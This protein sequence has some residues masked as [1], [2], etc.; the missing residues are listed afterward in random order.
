MTQTAF[1]K[2]KTAVVTGAGR[3][4]GRAIA[5]RLSAAGADVAVAA[6]TEP[7]LDET[8]RLIERAGGNVTAAARELRI[9]RNTLSRKMDEL[10]IKKK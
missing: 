5:R 1:L 8:R 7:Q 6:R 10:K 4:I 2:G 9:H 3:G